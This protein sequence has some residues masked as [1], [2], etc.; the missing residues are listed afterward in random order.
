[1]VPELLMPPEKVLT[2]VTAMPNSPA[3]IV[4][5]LVI[6]PPALLPNCCTLVTRMPFSAAEIVPELLMAPA[7]VFTVTSRMPAPS[8]ATPASP[9]E[10]VPELLRP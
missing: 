4:P 5:E 8:P 7:K 1:M 10:I 9:D 2:A 3:D 6:P